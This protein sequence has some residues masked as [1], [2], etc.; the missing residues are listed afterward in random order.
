[1]TPTPDVECD[2]QHPVLSVSDVVAAADFY[3]TKLGFK[4]AF[5][6][7]DPPEIAGVSRK[8]CCIRLRA[9]ARTRRAR[10]DSFKI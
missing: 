6:M 5:I 10:S 3:T 9:P 4:L 1:M 2:R 8:H 7:G